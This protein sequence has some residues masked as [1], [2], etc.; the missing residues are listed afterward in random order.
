M[1]HLCTPDTDL[2]ELVGHEETDGYHSGP[3]SLAMRAGE[4][5]ELIASDRLSPLI[6]LKLTSLV[7][8]LFI[9]ETGESISPPPR[10]RLLFH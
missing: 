2:D 4:E 5:L 8:G 9:V 3:L 1:R 10:F 7:C 6:Q